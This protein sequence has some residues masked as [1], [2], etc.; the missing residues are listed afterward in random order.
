MCRFLWTTL[1]KTSCKPD[2]SGT[3]CFLLNIFGVSRTSEVLLCEYVSH[4]G[5]SDSSDGRTLTIQ[6]LTHSTE[7]IDLKEERF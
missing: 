1:R 7:G 4:R 2:G 6:V 5:L 3:S